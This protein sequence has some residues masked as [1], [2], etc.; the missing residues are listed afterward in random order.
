MTA[1]FLNPKFRMKYTNAIFR[2]KLLF[3]IETWGG[4][5]NVLQN[6]VKKKL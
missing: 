3:T 2:S 6:K 4:C 1:K 5:S